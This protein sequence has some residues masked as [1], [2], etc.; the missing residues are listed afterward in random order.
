[1]NI[2]KPRVGINP[3]KIDRKP[4]DH[5]GAK[6]LCSYQ[7]GMTSDLKREKEIWNLRV[8]KICSKKDA[9]V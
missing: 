5:E 6:E 7:F 2:I 1:L 8:C 4:F 9:L 3:E